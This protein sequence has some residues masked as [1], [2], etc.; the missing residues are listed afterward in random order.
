MDYFTQE[1]RAGGEGEAEG[2]GDREDVVLM[3]QLSRETRG[4][5]FRSPGGRDWMRGVPPAPR[6]ESRGGGDTEKSAQGP[7]EAGTLICIRV[8]R[9]GQLLGRC[10][11]GGFE[12]KDRE[13]NSRGAQNRSQVRM[14]CMESWRSQT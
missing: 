4:N 5:G 12:G 9:Q 7:G 14:E 13:W 8:W 1:K 6:Q 11:R 2:T 3:E 10:S